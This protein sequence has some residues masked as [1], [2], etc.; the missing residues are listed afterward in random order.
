MSDRAMTTKELSEYI[1][2]PVRTLEKWRYHG[3]G[4]AFFKAEG[5][6]RYWKSV[7]DR[8]TKQ[9]QRTRRAS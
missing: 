4:P 5:R 2:V 3:R 9:P 6:A 1:N 7:V 8:W